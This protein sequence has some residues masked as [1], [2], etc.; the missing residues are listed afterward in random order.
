MRQTEFVPAE[1]VSYMEPAERGSD[2]QFHLY[3]YRKS[4]SV[5]P[6][7]SKNINLNYFL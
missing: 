5:C 4:F 2:R 7:L 1:G 3:L 6:L